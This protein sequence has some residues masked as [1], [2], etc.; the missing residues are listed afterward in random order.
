MTTWEHLL[1]IAGGLLGA[2]ILSTVGVFTRITHE[3]VQ[4]IATFSWNRVL[5]SLPSAILM[6]VIGGS[7]GSY[8]QTTY[9]FPESIAWALAGAL[10]YLGPTFINTGAKATISYFQKSQGTGPD[11]NTTDR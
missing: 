5:F 9:S 1:Q 10:G 2:I 11:V 6:G 8:L 4:N 7:L 3:H